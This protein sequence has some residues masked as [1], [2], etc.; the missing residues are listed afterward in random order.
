MKCIICGSTD[1]YKS[2]RANQKMPWFLR[3]LIVV[4]RCHRCERRFW[5][6]GPLALGQSLSKPHQ[7]P[8]RL[9]A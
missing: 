6:R 3:F 7:H 8:K 2:H 1:V 5:V 4:A 9:A